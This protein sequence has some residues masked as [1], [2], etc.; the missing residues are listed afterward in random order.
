MANTPTRRHRRT[1]WLVV[2]LTQAM[3]AVLTATGVY[4]AYGRLDRNIGQGMAIPHVAATPDDTGPQS[5]LNILVLGED[6][7]SGEG[8]EIDGE[9]GGGGADTTILL[10]VSA[11]RSE[12]YGVSLPR[13]AM[14]ARPDCKTG[15]DTGDDSVPGADPVMFNTAFAVGGPRCT[16]MMV[17]SLTEIFIDHFV[18]LDFNGF[19]RMVDAVNGV[20]V[21][22]PEDVD[23][24]G[25]T[26]TAGTQVLDGDA[27]LGYVRERTELSVTGD[28]GR[29]KRQQSFIASM[30]NKVFSAGT[31]SRP[32]RVYGFLD[33]VTGS[34]EVDAELDSIGALFDLAME[35]RETGLADIR[36]ITVPIAEYE[37]DPNRL[38]WTEDA[39]ALWRRIRQDRPLGAAYADSSVR[40][41]DPIGTQDPSSDGGT[42]SSDTPDGATSDDAD[43]AKAEARAQARRE[44]GL[45]V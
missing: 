42:D 35:F 34:L 41:D 36:F 1:I 10:H 12:A 39:D 13:D 24:K 9:S 8:N 2:A 20:E 29:M 45:C 4:V 14:V 18:V 7:R 37:P 11:D 26:L 38:Q 21:C 28:I 3:L 19:K 5:P 33:A 6:T 31:L 43:A 22:I 30:V 16:V 27:A 17:E 44:A 40:A 32:D 15:G 23:S 25:I